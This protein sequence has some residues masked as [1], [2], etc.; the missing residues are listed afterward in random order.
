MVKVFWHFFEGLNS[1][2]LLTTQHSGDP[3]RAL[4][5]TKVID[6]EKIF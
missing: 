2:T 4:K 1:M 5:N 6:V 3:F